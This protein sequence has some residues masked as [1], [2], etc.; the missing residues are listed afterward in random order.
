LY[1]ID[2]E[3]ALEKTNRKFIKRFNYLEEQTIKKGNSL[4]EMKLDDMNAIWEQAKK[5]DPK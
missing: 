3:T 2:P 4:K 5:F 1:G